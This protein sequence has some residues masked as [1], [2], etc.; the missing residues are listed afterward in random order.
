[1]NGKLISVQNSKG[2]IALTNGPII[3]EGAT[4]FQNFT[5]K[6]DGNNL[7]ISSTF[8]KKNS[9]N[10]LEWTIYPS[11]IIKMEVNYFPAEYFTSVVGVNFSFAESEIKGV[12]YMG[13]GPYRVWKNRIKGNKFGIWNKAYNNTET[14]EQWNYPEFKGYHSNMYWVKFNTTTQP[15]TVYTENEGLFFR[16]FTPAWKTDQWHNYEPIFP[17]GDISFMHG[18]SSI[19]SK[20][21]RNETSGPMGQKNIF[22]DYEKEPKRALKMV[23]YFDFR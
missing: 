18:I 17:T 13:N 8:E 16:L 10:T 5:N 22:Y 9:Y 21:N 11:G 2:N 19:G 14:G 6:F 12:Q 4:N 15:F 7:V 3:Q 20:T 1:L 23:L